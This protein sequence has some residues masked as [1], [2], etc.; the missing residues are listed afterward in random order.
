MISTIGLGLLIASFF[1]K[2]IPVRVLV[3]GVGAITVTL[4]I[5]FFV[6]ASNLSSMPLMNS[7]QQAIS[8]AILLGIHMY[9][10]REQIQKQ[11]DQ[12]NQELY[13]ENE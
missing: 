11:D 4:I 10:N 7:L 13:P 2:K 12:E 6:S 8:F 3:L 1:T 5:F 9:L